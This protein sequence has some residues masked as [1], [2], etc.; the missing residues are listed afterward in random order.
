PPTKDPPMSMAALSSVPAPTI[1]PAHRKALE[2]LQ[3]APRRMLIGG[4]WVDAISGKTFETIN[5]ATEE[6]LAAVAEADSADVDAAVAAARRAFEAPTW[7]G[8]SPHERTRLL[9]KI[10]DA[11]EQ[12]AEELAALETLNN[13]APLLFATRQVAN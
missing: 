4:Q 9:L 3:G 6:R 2:W 13:G 8:I 1:S 5:P 7:S 12:H 10:A 11:I